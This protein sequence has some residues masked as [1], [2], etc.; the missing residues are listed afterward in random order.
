MTER[1]FPAEMRKIWS[2]PAPQP[3]AWHPIETAPKDGTA[4][5]LCGRYND[6]SIAAWHGNGWWIEADGRR[7]VESQSDFGTEH[8]TFDLPTH[9]MPVPTPPAECDCGAPQTGK[10]A[11]I[12]TEGCASLGKAR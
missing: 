6:V 9:W 12:H 8:L 11:N 5:I 3:G 1:D 7:A 10:W 2:T 4:V